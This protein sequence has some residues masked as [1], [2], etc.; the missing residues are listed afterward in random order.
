MNSGGV[1]SGHGQTGLEQPVPV[2][3]I[4]ILMAFGVLGVLRRVR[5]EPQPLDQA[6]GGLVLRLTVSIDWA[7]RS[8]I[9]GFGALARVEAPAELAAQIV[10]ELERTRA[11]YRRSAPQS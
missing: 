2:E 6:D 5:H 10:A 4:A 8:W 9:L 7:L 11:R 1:R 3:H